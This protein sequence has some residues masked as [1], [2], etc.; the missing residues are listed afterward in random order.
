MY[1]IW[2]GKDAT[3]TIVEDFS[4]SFLRIRKDRIASILKHRQYGTVGV[5]YG[6]GTGFDARAVYGIRHPES[7]KLSYSEADGKEYLEKHAGDSYS[8]EED[9]SMTYRMYDGIE[10][11]LVLAEEIHMEDFDRKTPV[12]SGLTV[13]QR[14]SLWNVKQWFGYDDGQ[15]NVCVDTQRYSIYFNVSLGDELFIY[16]RVGQNGYCEKG[17][18]MLSTTCIRQ[19]ECRMIEDNLQTL[20]EYRPMEECFVADGCAFP[21]DGG[22]YWSLKE[23]TEDVIY[24][25]GCGGVTYEIHRKQ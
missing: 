8:V 14:M 18:A 2:C 15:F 7:G 21:S 12:D 22:W 3:V 5:V 9:G 11:P 10:F 24:L 4:I 1:G 13:A 20:R 23:V 16:C 19:M 25:H 6:V 17:W